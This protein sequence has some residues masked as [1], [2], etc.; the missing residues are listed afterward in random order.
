M[1]NS[2]DV[3]IVDYQLSNLFSVKQACE[4]VG[5]NCRISSERKDVVNADALILPGVGSF[6]DGISNLKKLDLAA[7][8][9]DVVGEGRPLLGV[10]LGLQLLFDSS[11][12]FGYNEGLGLVSGQVKQIPV[13]NKASSRKVPQINWNQI[14]RYH[15][16]NDQNHR[17][18]NI[19]NEIKDG[20][21]MY[22][23]HSYFVKPDD[24]ELVLTKTNYDGFEYCSSIED[25]NICA[26]QF[27]PEKSGR[28]GL[29]IYHNWA[30]QLGN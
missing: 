22:F 19:L 24:D 23:V 6:F 28:E 4:Y 2:L 21:N 7:P 30:K 12:E 26:F 14:H 17:Q 11:E 5:L 1:N 8:L 18:P 10:C 16:K 29:K 15:K 27:H 13:E 9:R 20:E 3:V 25:G